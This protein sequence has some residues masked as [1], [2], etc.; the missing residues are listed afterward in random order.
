MGKGVVGGR[1]ASKKKAVDTVKASPG[2][3]LDP[4]DFS[5][6]FSVAARAAG[7]AEEQFGVIAGHPLRGYT[8]PAPAGKPHIYLSSGIHGD[9]PAP[10]WAL[11]RLVESG[12]CDDR[13]SWFICPLLNPTG[14]LRRTRENAE[15]HDQNRDYKDLRTPEVQAHVAWLRR[16]PRFD[17]VICVHEDWESAGFYLY[18]LNIL[19]QPTLAHAMLAAAR[20]HCPIETAAVIDGRESAEPGIIRPVSDPLLRE[21]WPEAIYLR[22]HHGSL[23][24]TIESPSALPLEQRVTTLMAVLRAALAAF[25]Q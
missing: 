1:G 25:R 2:L 8:K 24:Y 14:F 6:R 13:F 21:T 15:G 22:E 17:L 23:H 19:N 4:A 11:L 16:Q 20:A 9:E 7:F 3:P 10:P 5:P 12:W 18:E